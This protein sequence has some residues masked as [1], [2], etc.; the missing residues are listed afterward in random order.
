MGY[1]RWEHHTFSPG[2]KKPE[3]DEDEAEYDVYRYDYNR[4]HSEH[5]FPSDY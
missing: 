5:A 4:Y 3:L 1:P 2:W